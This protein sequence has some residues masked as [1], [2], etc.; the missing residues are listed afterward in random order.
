VGRH[1]YVGTR[2]ER[3]IG[4]GP[5]SSPTGNPLTVSVSGQGTVNSSPLGIYGCGPAGGAECTAKFEGEAILTATPGVGYAFAGW[6]GCKLTGADTCEVDVTAPSEVTA[7][8]L[9]EGATGPTG[10]I[11]P[12]GPGGATGP[13]GSTGPAGANGAN[14]ATGERG[15]SGANG[16]NGAQGPAG[17]RGPAGKVEL[18]TCRTVKGKQH[19]TATLAS[20]TVKFTTTG[21]AARATLSRHGVVYAA[22][23]ARLARGRT[24]LRLLPVRRLAPGRYTLTL[25][26]GTRRHERISTQSFT[27]S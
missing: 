22:G 21:L 4:F 9:K 26:S 18:V 16:A 15:A 12:T 8:F 17:P 23:T 6:F 20:G 24:S 11:G 25:I 3:V 1:I 19:C 7:V 14:G 5:L 10:P 2:E 13:A 27:L